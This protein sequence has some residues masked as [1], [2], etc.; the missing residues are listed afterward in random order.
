MADAHVPFEH[1]VTGELPDLSVLSGTP[2]THRVVLSDPIE[3]GTHGS[4][5]VVPFIVR[6]IEQFNV[7]AGSN[8]GARIVLRGRVPMTEHEERALRR[9]RIAWTT[10]L[11]AALVGLV[12]VAWAAAVWSPG[13]AALVGAVIVVAGV[14]LQRTRASWPRGSIDDRHEWVT[15]SGVHESFAIAT[16]ELFGAPSDGV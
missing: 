2:T 6:F 14:G 10:L 12:A 15:I 13:A 7:T 16:R 9:R 8:R 3:D 4:G 5:R 1:Y 11:W